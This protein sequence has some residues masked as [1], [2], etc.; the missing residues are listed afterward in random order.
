MDITVLGI[1]LVKPVCSLA[2]TILS[3]TLVAGMVIIET[4][5]GSDG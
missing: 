4:T 3:K 2:C 5:E 1:A